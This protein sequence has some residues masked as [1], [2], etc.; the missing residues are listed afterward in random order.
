M[1]NRQ[2]VIFTM[3]VPL[4]PTSLMRLLA[5]RLSC[6]QTTT[7]SLV[8]PQTGESGAGSRREVGV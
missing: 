4:S 2:M 3:P 8:I 7:K 6:Q 5:I 1:A